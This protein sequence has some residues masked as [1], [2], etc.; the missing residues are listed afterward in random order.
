MAK[1][2]YVTVII[3]RLK[4]FKTGIAGNAT[5]WTG[6][7]ETPATTQAHIDALETADAEIVALENTLQQK[8]QALRAL[9]ATK[10]DVADAIELKVKGIHNTAPSKWIEYGLIDPTSSVA[11]ESNTRPVPEKGM[12]KNIV[13]DYDGIGFIIEW[14]KLANVEIYEIERGTAANASD[15]N[16]IPAFTHLT[17][18][19]KIKYTDDDVAKGTRYFY[20]IRGINAR[21]VGEWSEPVSRVQ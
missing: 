7:P 15:V 14:E 5:A 19:K 12:I 1:L 16:T 17:T 2:N 3:N 20:R 6:Q 9:A 8:R 11:T 21:G 4:A 10:S 13:D 18:I